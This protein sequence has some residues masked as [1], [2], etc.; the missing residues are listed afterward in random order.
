LTSYCFLTP[1]KQ[2]AQLDV[3]S[4]SSLKQQPSGRHVAPL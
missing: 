4:A 1:S 3:Y 2:H